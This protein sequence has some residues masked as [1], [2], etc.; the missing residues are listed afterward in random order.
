MARGRRNA[1]ARQEGTRGARHG[2]R[3]GLGRALCV[4]VRKWSRFRV[5]RV[6]ELVRFPALPRK[7]PVFAALRVSFGATNANTE[8]G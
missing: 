1:E 6:S 8:N 2:R 7:W 5:G 4:L 3:V